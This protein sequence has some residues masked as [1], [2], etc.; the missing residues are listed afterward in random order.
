M[1]V[2]TCFGIATQSEN[3][4]NMNLFEALDVFSGYITMFSEMGILSDEELTELELAEAT[5]R[6]AIEKEND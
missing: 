3:G 6:K 5:I 4:D 1:I 2:S